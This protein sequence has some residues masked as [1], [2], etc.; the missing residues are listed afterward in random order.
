MIRVR[1]FRERESTFTFRT[2]E[3][4]NGNQRAVR[5]TAMIVRVDVD[6]SRVIRVRTRGSLREVNFTSH[7]VICFHDGE[8]IHL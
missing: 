8:C 4:G 7:R 5:N 2:D 1:R 6:F 3:T